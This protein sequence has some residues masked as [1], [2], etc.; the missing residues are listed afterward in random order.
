[1]WAWLSNLIYYIKPYFQFPDIVRH[2][3]DIAIVAYTLYKLMLLIRETRAEQVLKGLAI[4]LF[5]TWMS[6]ILNLSTVHMILR[7]TAQLGVIALLIVFQPELRKAL[8]QIGR[9]RIFDKMMFL[10]NDEDITEI[11]ESIVGAVQNLSSS[12]TGAL[13]VVERKTGLNDVVE[14]G[15]RLDA[16]LT[17]ELLENIFVPNTPLH[18]GAVIIRES[19]IVAAGCFLPLT[20][21]PNLSKQ[22]GTRHRAALGISEASDAL[23][24][25]VSEETGIVSI[26]SDGKLT[27]YLD[28]EGLR[29]ILEKIYIKER[30]I[31]TF[32]LIKRRAKDAQ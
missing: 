4:L 19:R 1:M 30:E 27:R 3:V 5:A 15:V 20:E 13:I 17:R 21:N 7:N 24:I 12:R 11:I 31:K 8:E 2:V 16:R 10:Q 22:L 32:S 26:A 23:A 9:G 29:S 6:N 25:I 28:A 14:T 18:D